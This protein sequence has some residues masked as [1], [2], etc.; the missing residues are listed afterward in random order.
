MAGVVAGAGAGFHWMSLKT[1]R[2]LSGMK[3]DLKEPRRNTTLSGLV[4]GPT[5][6]AVVFHGA[7]GSTSTEGKGLDW[8]RLG[9]QRT[10]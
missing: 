6:V 3:R 5:P 1:Q 7:L 4:G 8:Q 9:K 2:G 10:W